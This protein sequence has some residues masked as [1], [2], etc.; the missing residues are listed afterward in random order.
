MVAHNTP[1]L[2]LKVFIINLSKTARLRDRTLSGIESLCVRNIDVPG[3]WVADA[4]N[5]YTDSERLAWF[6]R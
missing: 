3:H 5:I 6:Q 4:D 2:N 1:I